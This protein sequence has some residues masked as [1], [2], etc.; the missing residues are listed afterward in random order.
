MQ[1]KRG[2]DVLS[3][4]ERFWSGAIRFKPLHNIKRIRKGTTSFTGLVQPWVQ[5]EGSFLASATPFIVW[6]VFYLWER[7]N[8]RWF[9]HPLRKR[10]SGNKFILMNSGPLN[11]QS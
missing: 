6:A 8:L 9:L 10:K 2:T 1:Y 11:N 5:S 4:A 3:I 7:G